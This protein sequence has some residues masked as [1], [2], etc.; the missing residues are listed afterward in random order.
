MK[1]DLA[2][3]PCP[4]DTY[5]FYHLIHN[6]IREHLVRASF[7]DIEELNRRAI[8]EKKTPNH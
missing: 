5:I 8:E 6:G 7:F 1:Y 3:S 2:I 4:N